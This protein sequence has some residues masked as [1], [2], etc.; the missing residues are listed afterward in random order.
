MK[1]REKFINESNLFFF[2]IIIY[3]L[4]LLFNRINFEIHQILINFNIPNECFI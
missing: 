4:G 2:I 3:I 1:K